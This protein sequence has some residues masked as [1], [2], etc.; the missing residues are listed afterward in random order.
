MKTTESSFLKC[1]NPLTRKEMCGAK[2][3]LVLEKR[4]PLLPIPGKTMLPTVQF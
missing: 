1:W 2:K 3:L 4:T